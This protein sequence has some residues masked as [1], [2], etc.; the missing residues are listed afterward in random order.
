MSMPTDTPAQTD[1]Y[2]AFPW[3]TLID[4]QRKQAWS[5]T[6]LQ[7]CEAAISRI[8]V[9]IA[10]LRRVHAE[11]DRPLRVHTVCQH[12]HWPDL[13][14]RWADLG[15]TD[16]WLSHCPRDAPS[17]G[18]ALRLHA[19]PLYAVN[20]EDPA[21]RDGLEIGRPITERR[22]LASFAGAHMAHYIDDTRLR[23]ASLP[24]RPDLHVRIDREWHFESEVYRRQIGGDPAHP[25][26]AAE[27]VETY[28]RLLSDS[29]FSL[30]PPGAGENTLRL[31]ESLAVGA[32]P[33]IFGD[34]PVLPTEQAAARIEWDKI[35][36]RIPKSGMLGL[37]DRLD[38]IPTSERV[39][40]QRLGMQAY[41]RIRHLRCF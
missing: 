26:P 24:A 16:V 1:I 36:V 11:A 6:G 41:A 4:T 9:K 12:I 30:C 39:E 27:T 20:V 34:G 21:R 35:V 32:I 19:W 2:V 33:V 15:I 22:W 17:R 10:Y 37:F 18:L 25:L 31:W 38:A 5:E 29:V 40:R 7:R 13:A 14:P 8:S 3:A 23:L 28:N